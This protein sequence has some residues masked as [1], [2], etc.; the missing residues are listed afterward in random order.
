MQ[1]ELMDH[2]GDVLCAVVPS[3]LQLFEQ[4]ADRRLR[5]M[6]VKPRNTAQVSR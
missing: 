5:G 4:A 2:G 3:L 6:M 1:D